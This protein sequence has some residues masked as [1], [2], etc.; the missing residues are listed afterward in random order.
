VKGRG[1]IV[2]LLATAGCNHPAAKAL[3]PASEELSRGVVEPYLSAD[4]AL[5][6]DRIDGVK[7]NADSIGSAA[8]ALGPS[9]VAIDS[10]A[11]ELASAADL[12]DA[13]T[14]FGML[15]EAIDVYMANQHLAP[16]VGVRV[17]FCPMAMRPWLQRDGAIRNP[18]YGSQMLTCGSFRN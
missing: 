5:A 12:A 9:A 4:A 15:S 7:A 18:Y 3:L 6:S 17:A 8:R 16:P 1:V 14:K 13:R 11:M 10:A 2:F